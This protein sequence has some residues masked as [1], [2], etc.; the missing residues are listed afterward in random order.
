[1][2]IP[3]TSNAAMGTMMW[4][5][6]TAVAES[7]ASVPVMS[8]SAASNRERLRL[9]RSAGGLVNIFMMMVV[10]LVDC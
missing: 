8:S 3:K 4:K 7:N 5:A 1:M 6:N 2:R 9:A 10:G